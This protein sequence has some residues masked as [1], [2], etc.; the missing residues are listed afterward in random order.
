[1]G[2]VRRGGTGSDA[3]HWA[4][5]SGTERMRGAVVVTQA[6][7]DGGS[8]QDRSPEGSEKWSNS[9]FFLLVLFFNGY[10]LLKYFINKGC[11]CILK[12]VP[13]DWMWDVRYEIKN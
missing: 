9:R 3:R 12:I 8:D 2:G 10:V 5:D 11:R 4:E 1:M 6:R 13:T 7:G